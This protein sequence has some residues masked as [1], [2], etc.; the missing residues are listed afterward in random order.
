M[1]LFELTKDLA[2]AADVPL[3]SSIVG[4]IQSHN[5][6]RPM[7]ERTYLYIY[8]LENKCHE[9]RYSCNLF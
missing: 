6:V 1:T 5:N 4:Q 8:H 7:S 3:V 2:P 9:Q